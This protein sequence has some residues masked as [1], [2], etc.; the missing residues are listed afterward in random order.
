MVL[1]SKRRL[2][3]DL[4][5]INR[6]GIFKLVHE[7]QPILSVRIYIFKKITWQQNLK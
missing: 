3:F 5:E 6:S 2:H 4:T 1:C 7:I